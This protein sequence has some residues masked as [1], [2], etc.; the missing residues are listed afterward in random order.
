ME[1]TPETIL[2]PTHLLLQ[3]VAP[4]KQLLEPEAST[5]THSKFTVTEPLRVGSVAPSLTL[6]DAAG[7][8]AVLAEL[9]AAGPL[10][11]T[12]LRHFG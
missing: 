3:C 4:F 6:L 1:A 7:A 5:M 12:F 9:W 2:R 10:L 8:P 11:L